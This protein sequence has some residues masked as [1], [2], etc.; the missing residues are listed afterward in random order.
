MYS[1]DVRGWLSC[2]CCYGSVIIDP[3][4]VVHSKRGFF[5]TQKVKIP[6]PRTR[7]HLPSS[8]CFVSKFGN[9]H[10]QAENS[11]GKGILYRCV[12]RHYYKN[13]LL[14]S[15]NSERIQSHPN[16]LFLC[17]FDDDSVR[18]VHYKETNRIHGVQFVVTVPWVFPN[19]VTLRHVEWHLIYTPIRTRTSVTP[20]AIPTPA[21]PYETR[22]D[23]RVWVGSKGSGGGGVDGND[24]GND[25]R[26][27]CCSATAAFLLLLP[28][29]L[30]AVAIA[31]AFQGSLTTVRLDEDASVISVLRIILGSK[32]KRINHSSPTTFVVVRTVLVLYW[33]SYCT[34]FLGCYQVRVPY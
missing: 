25:G 24:D 6:V 27:W 5:V 30:R 31:A 21:S 11:K 28:I 9:S 26:C 19:E 16:S 3:S 18:F 22:E 15:R 29:P 23:P 1:I 10:C 13:L 32:E 4:V 14:W 33:A 17:P 8:G 2:R 34:V 20:M 7:R 12:L